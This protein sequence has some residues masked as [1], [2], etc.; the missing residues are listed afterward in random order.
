[1]KRKKTII[2]LILL[3]LFS[4]YSLMPVLAETIPPTA[5]RTI[6]IAFPLQ[7]GFSEKGSGGNYLGYTYD[8][9]KK[10][11]QYTGWEYEFIE[12][13]EATSDASIL[14]AMEMV[15]KGEAD[16]IGGVLLNDAT[17]K[18]FDF[19]SIGYG[20]V[21]TTLSTL[22]SNY[23]ISETTIHTLKSLRVAVLD[24]ATTR[25]TEVQTYLEQNNI[26]YEPVECSSIAE[27]K[28]ALEDGRADVAS[29]ISLSFVAGTRTIARFAPRSFYFGTTKGNTDLI[30]ELDSALR[31]IAFSFPY[32]ASDLQAQY[33]GDTS[34]GFSLTED[35]MAALAEK[36][37]FKVLCV[38]NNAPY[39]MRDQ[40]GNLCGVSISVMDAFAKAT[41]LNVTYDVFDG[42]KD[43]KTFYEEGKYDC[44][45]GIGVNASYNSA[46][47]LI[48][49]YPFDT[50][51]VIQFRKSNVNKP[52]SECTVVL[53]KASELADLLDCK[54]ILYVDN[55]RECV[56]AV[57]SGKADAGFGN[58]AC[59]AYYKYDL[60]VS[61]V[62][63]PFPGYTSNIVFSLSSELG[64]TLIASV[65]KY[66]HTIPDATLA[67]YYNIANDTNQ[68][69]SF[70]LFA[71]SNPTLTVFIVSVFFIFLFIVIFLLITSHKR[72]EQYALLKKA[73]TAKSE[74]LSNMSHDMRTPMNA[75]IGLSGL[76]LDTEISPEARNYFSSIRESGVYLLAL[77][78]DVLDMSRIESGKLML[79]P[80]P[81][82][83]TAFETDIASLLKPQADKKGVNLNFIF[84]TP[85][86]KAALFDKQRLQQICVNLMSNAIKF[87]PTG[88]TV[89]CTTTVKELNADTVEVQIIV[90]DNGIGMSQEFVDE[91]LFREF[92]QE[93]QEGVNLQESG[94]GLGLSIVKHL[95][96]LMDGTISCDSTL[97]KG[98]TFTVTLKAQ[99][100]D[101]KTEQTASS[102]FSDDTH[103]LNGKRILLCEDHPLNTQIAKRL[104]ERRGIEVV[105]AV[106]GQEGVDTFIEQGPGA[107]D[108]ILMDIRMPIMDGL[109][110]ARTIRSLPQADAQTIPIIAMTANAFAEDIARSR[111]AGMVAHL[112]KPIHPELLYRTLMEF[113]G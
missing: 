2:C 12:I 108:A 78:N 42:S 25:N 11:S 40:K 55:L 46:L 69:S 94:T 113:I 84:N 101:P 75:I 5:Q 3:C 22:E 110:A 20:T 79:H 28:K 70:E 97:G 4:P 17:Q 39:I 18:M 102:T 16:L 31:S 95:V 67:E 58:R 76:G 73:N 32:F 45:L 85:F 48:E 82:T 19:S 63:T 14:K 43:F 65:N 27:Q 98:T 71:R 72:K 62:E 64:D 44:V 91:H 54:K 6:R 104:L 80:E 8:Y 90:S 56:Q 89:S 35:Q 103:Q 7:D 87:T 33:F 107:F 99:I 112:A 47:H 66:L 100:V 60:N 92:E 24:G 105:C 53:P 41:G 52:L 1:M 77:I 57:A 109:T 86:K 9:L 13:D 50:R 88:G 37:D 21:Y 111:E 15:Q 10:I 34:G 68:K 51:D 26:L 83:Y 61:M 93:N 38:P 29:G 23:T 106:N 81:Y 59:I 30:S 49:S 74:F 96:A 36:K